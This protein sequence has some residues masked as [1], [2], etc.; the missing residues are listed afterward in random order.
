MATEVAVPPLSSDRNAARGT[1]WAFLAAVVA[2][3]WLSQRRATR[4]GG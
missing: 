4:A 2:A 3:Q 1:V